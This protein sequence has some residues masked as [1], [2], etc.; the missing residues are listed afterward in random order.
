MAMMRYAPM[1]CYPMVERILAEEGME[2][3]QPQLRG[4]KVKFDFD[5][6]QEPGNVPK[7]MV[8]PEKVELVLPTVAA[9]E[10]KQLP[11]KFEMNLDSPVEDTFGRAGILRF[12]LVVDITGRE[13]QKN[14]Q[15]LLKFNAKVEG[16][17]DV[18]RA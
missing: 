1:M 7:F 2:L 3:P 13:P 12:K 11:D 8:D 6:V 16:I 4:A 14:G 15:V 18:S 17:K 10:S 5:V 9:E